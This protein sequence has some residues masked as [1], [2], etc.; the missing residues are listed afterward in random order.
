MEILAGL[1]I[2][3]G[4]D[5]RVDPAEGPE[6]PGEVMILELLVVPGRLVVAEVR[7]EDAALAEVADPAHRYVP[8]LLRRR[9]GHVEADQNAD[10]VGDEAGVV[11]IDLV[12]PAERG[13]QAVHDRMA[14]IVD[15]EAMLVTGI[16]GMAGEDAAD[17]IAVGIGSVERVGGGVE[18]DER[19]APLHPGE[20]VVEIRDRQG[21]GGAA[22]D[23]AVE[24][25]KR[26][27]RERLGEELG[28]GLVP[29]SVGHLELLEIRLVGLLLLLPIGV[30]RPILPL[31]LLRLPGAPRGE[32][33]EIDIELPA[34]P[35]ES[36]EHPF[37]GLDRAV[38]E[39]VGDRHDEEPGRL[40]RR[41]VGIDS[42]RRADT[43]HTQAGDRQQE[44]D[45]P[46]DIAAN[47]QHAAP[48]EYDLGS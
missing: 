42:T 23:D 21:A 26:P 18:A 16:P 7:V 9:M 33:E 39:A 13:R 40:L 38:A 32:A 19:F 43:G 36:L 22:E 25:L 45:R 14:G 47:R 48:R 1:E 24:L 44:E 34:L 6:D 5:R 4:G 29:G 46:E 27:L 28:E 8:R 41:A 12:F 10:V 17:E 35:A 3:I 37:G 15:D 30:A 20:E 2:G 11:L 31:R